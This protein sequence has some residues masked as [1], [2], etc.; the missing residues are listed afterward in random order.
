MTHGPPSKGP[1]N[2]DVALGRAG[3]T[4]FRDM[5]FLAAVPTSERG[6]SAKE[7]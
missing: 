5:T 6:R 7:A 2:H 3:I 4:A 1:P